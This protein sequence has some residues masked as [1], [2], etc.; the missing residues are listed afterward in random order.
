MQQCSDAGIALKDQLALRG[1]VAL[2]LLSCG[3]GR[4]SGQTLQGLYHGST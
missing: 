3:P 2:L 1:A 4:S